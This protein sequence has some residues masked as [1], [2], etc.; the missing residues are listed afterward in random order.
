MISR[1]KLVELL[2]ESAL[3]HW[4]GLRDTADRIRAYAVGDCV[5]LR[6]LIEI[7]SVCRRNCL[8]CGLRSSNK[9]LVRYRMA[10]REIV[11]AACA[12]AAR[13]RRTVV[14]QAGEDP[15][16]TASRVARLVRCIKDAADVAMTLSLGEYPRDDYMEMREAGADRYLL[17]HETIDPDIYQAM[18]PGMSFEHR[19]RCLVWLKEAGFQVGSGVIVGLPGQT[20]ETLA[21]DI[22]FMRRLGIDM[23]GIGPF[24]PHPDTPLR[25]MPPGNMDLCLNLIAFTRIAIPYAHIPATTAMGTLGRNGLERALRAGANVLMP[26]ATPDMYMQGYDIYPGRTRTSDTGPHSV[27]GLVQ[28]LGRTVAHDYGHIQRPCRYLAPFDISMYKR[29][30]LRC[31]L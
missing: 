14:L 21:D 10:D 12:A 9:K 17:K 4:R 28:K 18:H 2:S 3:D 30:L 19:I 15:L 11:D 5:H 13:G 1:D 24:I 29:A 27:M 23:A 22:I 26:C 25:N 7:S 6:A 20:I 31:S 8:Y 16:L